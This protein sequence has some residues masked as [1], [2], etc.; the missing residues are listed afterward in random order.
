MSFTETI[1]MEI[2][3]VQ[4][5]LNAQL[6]LYVALLLGVA[7]LLRRALLSATRVVWRLGWDRTR[8]LARL[9][10]IS[11]ITIM[12]VVLLLVLRK[13]MLVA[14]IVTWL[15]V[16]VVA[17]FVAL[18][19]PNWIRDVVAGIALANRS[20]FREGDQVRF[21]DASGSVR[22]IGLLRTAIR[23]GDGGTISVPN[24]EVLAHTIQVGREQQAAPIEVVIPPDAADTP[25]ERE[26]LLRMAQVSP[27]RR[28]GSRPTLRE[29]DRGW[30]LSLQT[31]STRGVEGAR[32]ALE[33]QLLGKLDKEDA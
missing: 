5:R 20:R 32:R 8:R 9:R 28:G 10:S 13:L 26:M 33:R 1:L 21:M 15:S 25:E 6:V 16:A 4:G 18:A 3:A 29:T 31:W 23:A 30:V 12:S 22:H 24:R 17:L 7:L 14:P 11:D 2:A 27:F 19:L